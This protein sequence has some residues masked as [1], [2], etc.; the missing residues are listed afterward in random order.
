MNIHEYQARELLQKFDVATT[1]GKVALTVDEAEQIAR[2]LGDVGL[3]VKAQIHAGG[4][5]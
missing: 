4:R 2:E 1:R 3:V 5:G